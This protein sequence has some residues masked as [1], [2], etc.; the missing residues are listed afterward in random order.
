MLA[1]AVV[2]GLAASVSCAGLRGAVKI[3]MGSSDLSLSVS[4]MQC[5]SIQELE[6]GVNVDS[7]L[8][9]GAEFWIMFPE[10]RHIAFSGADVRLELRGPLPM[11]D[12]LFRDNDDIVGV[13]LSGVTSAIPAGIFL[14]NRRLVWAE[15]P[16]GLSRLEIGERAFG[17]TGLADV[18]MESSNALLISEAS[19]ADCLALAIVDLRAKQTSV[20][21]EA[22]ARCGSLVRL[23]LAGGDVILRE[24]AVALDSPGSTSPTRLESS[25]SL[26]VDASAASGVVMGGGAFSGRRVAE[27]RFPHGRVVMEDAA[28]AGCELPERLSLRGTREVVIGENALGIGDRRSP[29]PVT[30]ASNRGRPAAKCHS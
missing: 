7:S 12:G 9:I 30:S 16:R 18:R 14:D 6:V 23:D 15:Y 17:A 8:T 4:G 27:L 29:L 13:N 26:G 5:A 22:F 1:W 25:K 24:G 20:A 11:R 10:L 21:R 19:F 3:P 28:L 2:Y